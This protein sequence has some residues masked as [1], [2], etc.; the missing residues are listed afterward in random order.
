MASDSHHRWQPPRF[1]QDRDSPS[2]EI[3]APTV[4]GT[5]INHDRIAALEKEAHD[6]GYRD[7][8]QQGQRDGKSSAMSQIEQERQRLLGL[9]EALTKPVQQLSSEMEQAVLALTL[10]IARRVVLHELSVKPDAIIKIV[11]T[12][13]AQ[14]P[15]SGGQLRLRLHPRDVALLSEYVPELIQEENI[16]L[17]ADDSLAQG[18]CLAEV[19]RS[20]A[21][22]VRPER[23]WQDRDNDAV[24]AEVD[25]RVE[26]RWRQVL[27]TLFDEEL[28]Q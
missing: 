24:I 13:L 11:R 23:R 6:Q 9:I 3:K 15:V 7:G 27:A 21:Q 14:V 17:I 25:A 1:D 8:F 22:S 2:E 20:N 5:V 28:I 10:E 16:A 4:P 19:L 18:G 26:R 12:T